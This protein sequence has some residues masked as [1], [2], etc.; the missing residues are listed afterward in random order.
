MGIKPS[1]P[2]TVVTAEPGLS[3]TFTEALLRT[4]PLPPPA[5][6]A[7]EPG[8]SGTFAEAAGSPLQ[9]SA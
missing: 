5:V 3:E 4:K 6:E 1:S 2:R 7:P 8:L 9:P